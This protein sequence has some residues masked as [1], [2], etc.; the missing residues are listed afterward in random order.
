MT[1]DPSKHSLLWGDYT[2][3]TGNSNN[4]NSDSHPVPEITLS[5]MWVVTG[6]VLQ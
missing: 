4:S 5:A 2:P 3:W 6:R 1:A